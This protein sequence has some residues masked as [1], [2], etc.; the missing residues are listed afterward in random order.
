[1]DYVRRTSEAFTSTLTIN[2]DLPYTVK[3]ETVGNVTTT[4]YIYDDV[5]FQIEATVDAVQTHNARDA[6]KSAW[7]LTD[8]D[9]S[10]LGINISD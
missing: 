10:R 9:I 4:T 6:I 2:A 1:M 7:G 8:G 3:T 5:T